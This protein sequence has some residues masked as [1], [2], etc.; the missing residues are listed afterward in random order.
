MHSNHQKA[1]H[2]GTLLYPKFGF[3][4][5]AG[6]YTN[7]FA[8]MHTR[9]I[10]VLHNGHIPLQTPKTWIHTIFRVW[11]DSFM[12]FYDDHIRRSRCFQGSPRHHSFHCPS[13]PPLL[14]T[15]SDQEIR[16]VVQGTR[17]GRKLA[18]WEKHI[19]T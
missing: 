17:E 12:S 6:R 2:I 5:I 16:E 8:K 18:K 4:H 15:I 9:L 13:S 1:K 11:G 3:S 19:P 7:S 10:K 14:H